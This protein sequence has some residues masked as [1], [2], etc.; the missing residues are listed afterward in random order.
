MNFVWKTNEGTGK[1]H[2]SVNICSLAVL[3]SLVAEGWCGGAQ[4]LIPGQLKSHLFSDGNLVAAISM[5]YFGML[6]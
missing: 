4:T 5:T 1:K 2:C 3:E 6:H